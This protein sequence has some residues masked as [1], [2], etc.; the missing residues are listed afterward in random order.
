MIG[1]DVGGKVLGFDLQFITG[2][3]GNVSKL[4]KSQYFHL[5]LR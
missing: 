3:P 4:S 1:T 5:Q 2:D